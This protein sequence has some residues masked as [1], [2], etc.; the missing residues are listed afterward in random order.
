MGTINFYLSK[1]LVD[2]LEKV[3]NRSALVADLLREHFNKNKPLKEIKEEKIKQIDSIAKEVD[4]LEEEISEEEKQ[5]RIQK[6]LM[7]AQYDEEMKEKE[8]KRKER[9]KALWHEI[10]IKNWEIEPDKLEDLFNEYVS[11]N[12]SQQISIFDFMKIKL[13]NPKNKK[14]NSE[15]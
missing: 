8:E 9:M 13:I 1:D 5:R 6:A 11:M 12:E 14:N 10:F 2:E 15:S 3:P 4:K 7:D